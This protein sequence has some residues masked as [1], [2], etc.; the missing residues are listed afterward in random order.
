MT[1]ETKY[2]LEFYEYLDKL[3]RSGITNMYGARPYLMADFGMDEDDKDEQ[4][5]AG[6]IVS[7][8]ME[9]FSARREAG[10]TGD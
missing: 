10:E 1:T 7:D 8:W 6:L 9:T 2:D 3:R 4:K 5:I